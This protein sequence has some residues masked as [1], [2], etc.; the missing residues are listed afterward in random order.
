MFMN[1]VDHMDQY[2]STLPTQHKELRL[3]MTIFKFLLD[4]AVSQ[5]YTVYQKCFEEERACCTT[6]FNVKC[7]VCELLV[8]PFM[9]SGKSQRARRSSS[10]PSPSDIFKTNN[11]NTNTIDG[12]TGVIDES[13]MLNENLPGKS[14]PIHPQNIDCFLYWKMGKELKLKT[15]YSCPTSKRHYLMSFLSPSESQHLVILV[16]L[17]LDQS[18]T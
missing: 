16:S 14:N 4:L 1:G 13:Y 7:K 5:A 9:P 11:N 6:F 12:T 18:K 15:S 3:H 2:R 8:T 17:L 10:T